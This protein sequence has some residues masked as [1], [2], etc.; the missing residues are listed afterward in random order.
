[1]ATAIRRNWLQLLLTVC[2]LLTAAF[3]FAWPTLYPQPA[4]AQLQQETREIDRQLYERVSSIRQELHLTNRD[5]A[6]MGCDQ[7]TAERVLEAAKSW[8]ESSYSQLLQQD[9]VVIAAERDLRQ[10]MRQINMGPRD[11]RVVDSL[12]QLREAVGNAKKQRREFLATA[13]MQITAPLD[14]N[15]RRI[16]E[17]IQANA[18]LPGRLRYAEDLTSEQVQQLRKIARD[19]ARNTLTD[20]Q[21]KEQQ[22]LQ[23]S[24]SQAIDQAKANLGSRMQAVVAAEQNVLPMPAELKPLSEGELYP[25]TNP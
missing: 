18:H 2:I 1:M 10:A 4:T 22:V 23:F 12:P 15:A 19:A 21:T 3:W 14:F 7:T 20:R 5:L 25:N 6:A 13:E 16:H 24:Q 17:T 11:Q 8:C 9:A